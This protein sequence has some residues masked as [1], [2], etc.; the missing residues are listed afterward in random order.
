MAYNYTRM[1]VLTFGSICIVLLNLVMQ[2]E[3]A[4]IL[5]QSAEE[6]LVNDLLTGYNSLILPTPNNSLSVKV[7]S[8]NIILRN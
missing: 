6:K 8:I 5:E 3:C 2:V 1:R 4:K 7:S